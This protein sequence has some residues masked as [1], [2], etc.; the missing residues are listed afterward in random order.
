MDQSTVQTIVCGLNV[1]FTTNTKK[2]LKQVQSN[3]VIK[4]VIGNIPG[5]M[6]DWFS[7]ICCHDNR[8]AT[9][10]RLIK[11]HNCTLVI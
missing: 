7:Q 10:K 11:P 8:T 3:K 2:I 9:P 6:F 1:F 4:N 5:N